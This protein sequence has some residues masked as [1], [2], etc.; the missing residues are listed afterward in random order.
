MEAD[1][2][3]VNLL[4]RINL[5]NKNM[6][7]YRVDGIYKIINRYIHKN[8]LGNNLFRPK[9][10]KKHYINNWVNRTPSRFMGTSYIQ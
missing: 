10:L 1:I 5:S 7:R 3:D 4:T 9:F 2:V 6:L 8:C